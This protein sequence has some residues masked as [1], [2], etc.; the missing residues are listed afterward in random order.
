MDDPFE[1]YWAF[2]NE[3]YGRSAQEL[4]RLLDLWQ[5]EAGTTVTVY[6]VQ[7]VRLRWHPR[8]P[9]PHRDILVEDT[10]NLHPDRVTAALDA[11]RDLAHVL[12]A[13]LADPDDADREL[14]RESAL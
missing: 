14:V 9:R 2:H 13:A 10:A 5:F 6:F 4:H 11:I 8:L 3:P 1:R 7:S 12:G